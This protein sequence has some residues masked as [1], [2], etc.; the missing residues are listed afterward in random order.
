[1]RLLT[2]PSSRQG[3]SPATRD[4]SPGDKL[5]T[6]RTSPLS[7]S[8]LVPW[9][10]AGG[11]CGAASRRL[12]KMLRNPWRPLGISA[13]RS[14]PGEYPAIRASHAIRSVEGS[15]VYQTLLRRGFV[16]AGRQRPCAELPFLVTADCTSPS[17]PIR[18]RGPVKSSSRSRLLECAA[19][20]SNSIGPRG[21]P[22]RLGLDR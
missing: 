16:A 9:H 21:A 6:S 13:D 15:Q 5:R 3:A 18:R 14:L 4:L 11:Y 19:A 12:L 2:P 8:D 20:I 1:M 7:R 10:E 17:S 22:L